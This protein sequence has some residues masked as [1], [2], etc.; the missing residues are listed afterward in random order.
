MIPIG[1]RIMDWNE[2]PPPGEWIGS[3]DRLSRAFALTG[4]RGAS[5]IGIGVPAAPDGPRLVP[6]S[7]DLLRLGARFA[8]VMPVGGLGW[9]EL[10]N[11][12]DAI[13]AFVARADLA[14]TASAHSLWSVE[15]IGY[16]LGQAWPEDPEG[17]ARRDAVAAAW[18][19][20]PLHSGA[21]L[22]LAARVFED[23]PL[24]PTG[25]D[26]EPRLR[27][28][29]EACRRLA[30][31]GYV[32]AVFEALGLITHNVHPRL[33]GRVEEGLGTIDEELL[34]LFWHGAGRALYLAPTE[35]WPGSWRHSLQRIVRRATSRRARS[36]Y[37][38]GFTWALTL[39]NE[40]HQEILAR[41]VERHAADFETDEAF[42]HGLVSAF[43]LVR[44]RA[45]P[46]GSWQGFLGTRPQGA[47]ASL[48]WRRHVV[49]PCTRAQRELAEALA[50]TEAW[51][52][53]L[54]TCR[55]DPWLRGAITPPPVA[56]RGSGEKR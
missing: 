23:L 37:R 49:D 51:G 26:L 25:S 44:S 17:F 9:C 24:R 14:E 8:S 46:A 27:R 22:A 18:Q 28:F 29:I 38:A 31:P 52:S 50:R 15:A 40:R 39:V 55:I 5:G 35:A 45:I 34:E 54:R 53:L 13:G 2:I 4:W 41:F 48:A 1:S 42:V 32:E 19:R 21:G 12:L 10:G 3:M 11:K 36:A 6:A 33:L 56:L 16:R 30:R 7:L 43:L 47:R 20:L